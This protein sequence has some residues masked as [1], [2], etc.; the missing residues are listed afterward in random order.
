MNARRGTLGLWLGASLLAYAWLGYGQNR[1]DFGTLL[2][3]FAALFGGYLLALRGDTLAS[4]RYLLGA[5]ALFRLTFLL[6]VPAL[7][8]DYVRFVWDGRWG[9][10]GQ[11]PYLILPIEYPDRALFSQLNSPGYYTVYPPLNQVF[12]ALGAWLFPQNLLGHLL[13]LRGVIF[14]GEAGTVALLHILLRRSGKPTRLALLYALNPLVIVELS[15]NLHFE[16]V[17]LALL[18]LAVWKLETGRWWR[19]ALA[20]SGAVAVKL[21]PLLFL[22]VLVRRM[23]WGKALV[24]GGVVGLVNVALFG[25]FLE[26]ALLRN[27]T[28]SLN[29]YFQ[30]FEF[31]AS[32]YY[33]VRE[34][35]FWWKGYNII[36]KAGPWL[37]AVSALGTGYLALRR[38]TSGAFPWTNLLFIHTLYL[39]LATTVHP[40]YLTY[41]IGFAALTPFRYPLVWSAMAVLS[42]ATYANPDFRENLWLT[43]IAYAVV[44]GYLLWELR[45]QASN[46]FSDA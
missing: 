22:P 15:G 14:A 45:R 35:G 5:A 20:W 2:A 25:P 4:E 36:Q 6:A 16:G 11:N 42:Y 39:A 24:F 17:A 13:V 44:Y 41:L 33:L 18:L 34:V 9:A 32:L 30:K 28:S 1:A 43:A 46:R 23:E 31:N 7:S 27:F 12:F 40:W 37:L 26:P 29:L 21:I 38:G 19:A 10:E 8:D 3:T